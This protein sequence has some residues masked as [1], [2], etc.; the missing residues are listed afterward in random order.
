MTAQESV[1]LALGLSFIPTP[2]SADNAEL[3]Y[4]FAIYKRSV[5]IKK[6]LLSMPPLQINRLPLKGRRISDFQPPPAS[7]AI[8]QY[9]SEA[10]NKLSYMLAKN[11]VN[12]FKKRKINYPPHFK[13]T[14]KRLKDDKGIVITPSDKNLGLVVVDRSWYLHS[15]M[16]H[17]E[18]VESY[19]SIDY[20]IDFS[21]IFYTLRTILDAYSLLFSDASRKTLSRLASYVLSLENVQKQR[22]CK[23]YLL[24]KI[25][26]SPM[27]SRPISSNS[28]YLSWHTSKFLDAELK[29]LM[30]AAPSYIKNSQSLI[31]ILDKRHFP[32]ECVLLEADV[33]N[34]YPSIPVEDGLLRLATFLHGTHLSTSRI[35]LIMDLSRWVLENNYCTFGGKIYQQIHGTAMGTP[36]AVVYACLY[37]TSI[38]SEVYSKLPSQLYRPLFFKRYIDDIFAIFPTERAADEFVRIFNSISP[39]IHLTAKINGMGVNFLDVTLFKGGNFESTNTLDVKLYQKPINKYVYLPPHSFHAKHTFRSIILSELRRYR[40][41][42]SVDND[43][44][45]AKELFFKRLCE[46]G[47]KASD[48]SCAFEVQFDR[49]ALLDS[50]DSITPPGLVGNRDNAIFS[51]K[52]TPRTLA[53]NL[54][55][56][57]RYPQYLFNDP[58]ASLC[59]NGAAPLISYKSTPN[60]GHLVANRL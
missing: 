28:K 52:R 16:Q 17:L 2:A 29:P 4:N 13:E 39:S 14:I 45:T 56:V 37:L 33:D 47:H 41:N 32:F 31:K 59:F 55:E 48:I 58:H 24:I 43:Y 54:R 51:C 19:K 6:W 12:N 21:K 38:E 11:P 26:K 3:H 10:E 49:G 25:H 8:E 15:A 42:C 57:L 50:I 60:L 30:I 1:V 18:K 34:L 53:M 5:R 46:R 20:A 35:G 40:I 44:E 9:L 36:F 23:F 27:A 22:L 7:S